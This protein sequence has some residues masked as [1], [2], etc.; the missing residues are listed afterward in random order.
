VSMNLYYVKWGKMICTVKT[1]YFPCVFMSL[2]LY[3]GVFIP[4]EWSGLR[5]TRSGPEQIS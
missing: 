1:L 4:A 5:R 3:A 2:C